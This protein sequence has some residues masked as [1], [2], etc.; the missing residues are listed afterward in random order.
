MKRA[1]ELSWHTPSTWA[2]AALED[3]LTLLSDHAH[4]EMGATVSAQ[5]LIARYPTETKLVE[6]M[7]ALAVEELRHFNQVHRLIVQLGG[8]LQ[9]IRTNEYAEALV[10]ET[11]KRNGGLVDRL[12]VSA[13]I[14]R[15]SLERFELLAE[16]A[17]TSHPLLAALYGELAPSEAGHA[18]LFVELA[19]GVHGKRN[20]E[21]RLAMWLEEEARIL[22]GL[23]CG[24]RIHSG[25]PALEAR[26]L[27][28]SASGATE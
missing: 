22:R 13:V 28:V 16:A 7:G 21:Q 12:L 25:P 14:E 9:P 6:R 2:P 10:R 17:R 19:E 5:G 1:F 3:P 8:T 23:P 11:R 4:C 15:R 20:V 18:S 27:S 24:P 26:R